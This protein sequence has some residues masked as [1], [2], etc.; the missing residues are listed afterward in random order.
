MSGINS[1]Y[2]DSYNN[3][4]SNPFSSISNESTG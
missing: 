4:F 2:D 3:L 1:K